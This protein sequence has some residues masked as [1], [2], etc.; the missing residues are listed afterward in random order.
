MHVLPRYPF[1]RPPEL[2]GLSSSD[3]RPV[4]VI[5]G[6]LTGLALALDLARRGVPV[7]V[8][9]DD[10][11]VGVR[12]LASRGM[13]WAQRTLDIFERLG[14]AGRISAKGVAWNV[15]RVLARDQPVTSYTLQDQPDLRHNGF[16]N[17]QQYYV[18]QYL[19]EALQ[20]EPLAE[21]R[22]LNKVEHMAQ[23]PGGVHL[24]VGTPDG[25][26]ELDAQ[27]AVA[28]DGAASPSRAALGLTPVVHDR[29]EDR[30]IIID[31]TAPGCCWAQERWTW[32]DASAN[33]GRAV[34]RHKMA[35]D[36]WRLD[37]Q[38]REDE[39]AVAAATPEA[40]RRRVQALF[41]DDLVFDIAWSGVWAYRHECLADLRCGRVLFAGDAA[42][43]VA[44]FGA[45]GGNGG[46][47]DADNLAWKL[48]L[49]LNHGA[50]EALLD[51]YSTE[52][53]QGAFENIRQ[54]R[55]SSRFVHPQGHASARLWRDAI[56]AMAPHLPWAARSINTGRLS[57]PCRYTG[58]PLLAGGAGDG[59]GEGDA[60]PD[61]RL[62]A[63]SL[64]HLLGPWFTLLVFG[65]RLPRALA[66]VGHP[67]LSVA[68]VEPACDGLARAALLRQL[69][70]G[71][72]SGECWLIRPDQH[73]ATRL[74]HL[75]PGLVPA[76]LARALG[77]IPMTP[78]T[79]PAHD[80]HAT[81]A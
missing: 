3:P 8:L 13:C 78:S 44:P 58:S 2:D 21:V 18:E 34:W 9:D 66:A 71:A 16:A 54:A 11:T 80:L 61:V 15:A 29:T 50:D 51:S 45:R 53:R 62:A 47:Q 46:V 1:R 10:D 4:V 37:F 41:G 73:V 67:L 55:R 32:L 38:L 75:Q 25:T 72:D 22:W 43:L 27:W 63:T 60:L 40:M 76:L 56:I 6:G 20:A 59:A 30:W 24:T 35:D 28:C 33:G 77:S 57:A 14:V 5:G 79:A 12:G 39:D 74:A 52:R 7:L 64:H 81:T 49:V 23:H 19:V 68:L 36:T 26:Y 42:H 17:L 70:V 31:I 48:A 69:G 65:D